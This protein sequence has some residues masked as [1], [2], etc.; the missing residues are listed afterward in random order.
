MDKEHLDENVVPLKYFSMKLTNQLIDTKTTIDEAK[1]IA[2]ICGKRDGKY[3]LFVI[4]QSD[5]DE[6]PIESVNDKIVFESLE[7]VRRKSDFKEEI[8]RLYKVG[9]KQREI[10]SRLNM[11][12]AFVSRLL[13]SD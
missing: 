1:G 2:T 5:Y 11:S 13:N 3:L 12:Q 6:A 8:K 10:A 9:L 4:E 7:G